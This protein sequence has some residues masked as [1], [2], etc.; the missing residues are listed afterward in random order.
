MGGAKDDQREDLWWGKRGEKGTAD[1]AKGMIK[2]V[3]K[4]LPSSSACEQR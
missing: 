1:E 3:W 4:Y 2:E